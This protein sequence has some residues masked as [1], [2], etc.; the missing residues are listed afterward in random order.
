VTIEKV[1]S[2]EMT[3]TGSAFKKLNG[4]GKVEKETQQLVALLK[5]GIELKKKEISRFE[6]ILF[7]LDGTRAKPA[8]K[9]KRKLSA[10]AR[11]KI[12][13]AAKARWAAKRK[14]KS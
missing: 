13:A 1:L 8:T 7:M 4:G 11:A 3:S 6:E 10:A 5:A 12:G 2:N 9:V 14:E